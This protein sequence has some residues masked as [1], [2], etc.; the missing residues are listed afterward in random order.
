MQ[1]NL[2]SISDE[3]VEYLRKFDNR[4]YDNKEDYRVHTRKYL[5]VVLSINSFNYYIPFSSPK[6]TDY[7]DTEKRK[8]RK[9]VI[10]IIRMTEK[11]K[12]GN[13]KLYGTLR[14]SNMI[15][16]PITEITPYFV[17]DEQD[18]NYKNLILSEL[19]FIKKNT[20]LI[21]KN[22]NVLYKQK[23]NQQDIM[24][25]KNSLDFKLLEEKCLE[26]V[27]NKMNQD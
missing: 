3:Y 9:S 11:D 22:A 7:Y 23:E 1:L 5:G 8:I 15:P 4:V 26:Y 6:D 14:I 12:D 2:Y 21:V 20:E 17:K 13:S 24:Y 27:E 19:R 16:V 10:P 18:I 25:V